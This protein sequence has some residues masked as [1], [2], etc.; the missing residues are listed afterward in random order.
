MASDCLIESGML[1][2]F[3]LQLRQRVDNV[4]LS[5]VTF[6][7]EDK[8]RVHGCRGLLAVRS[9]F[10]KRLLFGQMM[11]SKNSTVELPAVS[12]QVPILVMKFLYTG[13]VVFEDLRSSI[14][15]VLSSAGGHGTLQLDWNF[16]V[17]ALATTHFLML[18][19]LGRI[20]LDQLL[21]DTPQRGCLGE[22]SLVQ[23][24]VSFSV[25]HKYPSI[26]TVDTEGNSIEVIS[27]RMIAAL[28]T[29]DLTPAVLSKLSQAAFECYL[30]KSRETSEAVVRGFLLD[31]YLR[32][33]EILTWCVVSTGMG[34]S[35]KLDRTCLPGATVAMDIVCAAAQ[36]ES[37]I[38]VFCSSS[39][40]TSFVS[41]ISKTSLEPL[42]R[43][44]DF[45]YVPT[46]L[47]CGVLQ[48][49]DVIG[50]GELAKIL[51]A[52]AMRNSRRFR[53]GL[54]A[55]EPNVWQLLTDTEDT[56]RI[57]TENDKTLRYT[58]RRE[59][60]S[61]TVAAVVGL[62]FNSEKLSWEVTL[63]P[64]GSLEQQSLANLEFGFISL[65][66]GETFPE[67]VVSPIS[68]DSRS[69]VVRVE[70]DLKTAY[71]F[72]EGRV[73]C[74][75]TLTP[76]YRFHWRKP[77]R[78]TVTKVEDIQSV[79]HMQSYS[80]KGNR[81]FS[82]Y[83]ARDKLV[84]PVIYWKLEGCNQILYRPHYDQLTVEI[85]NITNCDNLVMLWWPEGMVESNA[86]KWRS[87]GGDPRCPVSGDRNK[88]CCFHVD[89]GNVVR[90]AIY[91]S[92]GA[93]EQVSFRQ[94]YDQ[95]IIKLLN[96]VHR[97]SSGLERASS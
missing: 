5:D 53:K 62:L 21:L 15:K 84:Y 56:W 16:L 31:E 42:L 29:H 70:S 3:D 93:P 20:L 44:V 63:T 71:G 68:A 13:K 58:V 86:L 22:D 11:E 61:F 32:V 7:C 77:Y 47:L 8:V 49:L 69:S 39:E 51:R 57:P 66:C 46:E 72:C 79:K 35:E 19:Q 24:A 34:T 75:W 41:R 65:N 28:R 30:E 94:Y 80:R 14:S 83:A 90:P 12:S 73:V 88:I 60:S 54:N 52:Q 78:V 95:L 43:F 74:T 59:T 37:S 91:F 96:I 89:E 36:D 38:P 82:F 45:T 97:D 76:Y 27:G 9:P 23:L 33:R 92:M 81:E 48:P 50:P 6:I 55:P 4:E 64:R 17:K 85:N 87:K 67:D 18:D 2:E 40:C 1:N 26:W 10:F 25:L